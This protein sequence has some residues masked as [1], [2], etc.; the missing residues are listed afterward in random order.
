MSCKRPLGSARRGALERGAAL[1]MALMIVTLVSTL[2]ASM[3]WQQWRAVQVESAVRTRSQSAWILAVALDWSRVILRADARI[4]QID[5]LTEPW[6]TPLAEAR[7]STFLAADSDQGNDGPDVFLSG[8]ITDAQAR[9][10]LRNLL[11]PTGTVVAQELTNLQALCRHALV[12][13][14]A[15]DLI[16][17]GLQ[18]ANAR[19]APDPDDISVPLNPATVDQLAWFGLDAESLK[20]LKPF[21]W[22]GEPNLDPTN[23]NAQTPI[24]VNTAPREVLAAVLSLNVGSAE[25]IVQA[26]SAKAFDDVREI[27]ALFPNPPTPLVLDPKR[28]DVKSSYFWVTGRIRV[29]TQVVEQ[30]S[31]VRREPDRQQSGYHKVTA[32]TREMVN[33]SDPD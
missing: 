33:S 32:L 15:A 27:S 28:V 16:A 6:A 11:N 22:L 2:A 23:P 30:R 12:A 31:L 7:V 25:R 10:N 18:R 8:Y 5:A 1:L 21:V 17:Q 26:R 19:P 20:R 14:G 9:Y 24:N 13:E 3:V 4:T 29:D